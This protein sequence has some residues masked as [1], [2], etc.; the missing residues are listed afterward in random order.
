MN[1]TQPPASL[2]VPMFQAEPAHPAKPAKA[3]QARTA[4]Q[5]QRAYRQRRKQ[6]VTQAIGDEASA[7][8]VTLL[9]LLSSDL[10][11]L[12]DDTAKSMHSAARNSARRVLST[13]V[14][15]YGIHLAGE[16]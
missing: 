12:E 3:E 11:L 6:A 2:D 14:T 9:A 10:A 7:S 4:A 5:R 1:D 13:L 8:R 15:R 16:A